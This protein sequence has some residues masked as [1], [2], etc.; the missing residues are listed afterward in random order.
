M[1]AGD[2]VEELHRRTKEA[3]DLVVAQREEIRQLKEAIAKYEQAAT[4]SIPSVKAAK[5]GNK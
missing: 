2:I 4:K 1:M 5:G 3:E